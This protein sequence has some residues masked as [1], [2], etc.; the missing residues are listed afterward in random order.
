MGGAAKVIE[1]SKVTE[2]SWQH[3]SI[4]FGVY[5]EGP[6]RTERGGGHEERGYN[7]DGRENE[8]GGGE[9]GGGGR[10]HGKTGK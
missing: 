3:Y 4:R 6:K 7:K 2:E 5:F 10:V 9:D 1:H 8:A